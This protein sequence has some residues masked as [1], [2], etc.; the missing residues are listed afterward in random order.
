MSKIKE[1]GNRQH[2]ECD[3]C[4]IEDIKEEKK[5]NSNEN[6]KKLEEFSEKIIDYI[7]N[8]KEIFEILIKN[9]EE[10]KTK[11]QKY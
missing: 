11:N 1:K 8:L 5:N 7:N 3:V 2:Y 6:I 10:L 9:K 4:C